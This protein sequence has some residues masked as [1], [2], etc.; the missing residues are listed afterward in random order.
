MVAVATVCGIARSCCVRYE[1]Y[2]QFQITSKDITSLKAT[3]TK[4]YIHTQPKS[5]KSLNSP[6]KT[7]LV[8]NIPL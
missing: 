5:I 4:L 3:A 8:Q 6:D 7:I 2:A 1:N